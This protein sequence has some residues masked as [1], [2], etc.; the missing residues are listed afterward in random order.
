MK[1]TLMVGD[2]EFKTF[3]AP[4]E[5]IAQDFMAFTMAE[6]DGNVTLMHF[7]KKAKVNDG[8]IYSI[9]SCFTPAAEHIS[10]LETLSKVQ[11][12]SAE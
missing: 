10:G 12:E 5:T 7:R 8:Y 2:L 11:D 3:E 9:H 6:D 1:I 4:N